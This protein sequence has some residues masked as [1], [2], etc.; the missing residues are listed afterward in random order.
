MCASDTKITCELLSDL[1]D[2]RR[3]RSST[4]VVFK[5]FGI[6]IFLP[7]TGTEKVPRKSNVITAGFGYEC[8]VRDKIYIILSHGSINLP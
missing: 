3:F 7:Q 8:M 1:H 4:L 5:L 6:D 2:N